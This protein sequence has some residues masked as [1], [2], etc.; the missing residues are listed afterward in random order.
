MAQ[1]IRIGISLETD[2]SG[3]DEAQRS[4]DG[5]LTKAQEIKTEFNSL[6]E[7][8]GNLF[9]DDSAG[10][11]L[12]GGLGSSILGLR[13]EFG[14]AW[15]TGW[16]QDFQGL[17]EGLSGSLT[18]GIQ[19]AL[20]QAG[21]L[22]E[23]SWQQLCQVPQKLLGD[24]FTGLSGQASGAGGMG[25]GLS[26]ILGGLLDGGQEGAGGEESLEGLGGGQTSGGGGGG[27]LSGLLGKSGLLGGVLG[28][29][30]GKGG[31]S[32]L[33]SFLGKGS[34]LT[35]SLLGLLG[36][37][38]ILGG[39]SGAGLL[40]GLWNQGGNLLSGVFG[41]GSESGGLLSGVFG[42]GSESGGLLSGIFGGGSS[43]LLSVAGPL[44]AGLGLT[45]L[46]ANLLDMPGPV[47]AIMGALGGGGGHSKESA[48]S[49]INADMEYL[50]RATKGV[51]EAFATAQVNAEGFATSVLQN[52]SGATEEMGLLADRAGLGSQG[53]EDMVKNLDPLAANLVEASL[54]MADA[55]H[56]I[57][58][59]TQVLEQ[60]D[61]VLG[62]ATSQTDA[63][64]QMIESL[65]ASLNLPAEQADVLNQSTKT[66]IDQFAMGNGTVE[67]LSASLKQ[68]FATALQATARDAKTTYEQMKNLDEAI[69]SIPTEWT[70]H[71]NVVYDTQGDKPSFH[72]GGRIM[73][74]GG[75]LGGLPRFHSGSQVSSLAHD[76]VPI[77]AR[78]GEYIVR[79]ESVNAATLPLLA[80]L[81]QTGQASAGQATSLPPQVNLH[82]EVH[83]NLLGSEDNL[84]ELAR[85]MER[86]L[87]DLDQARYG[88]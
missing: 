17:G 19:S 85:L 15:S 52:M 54:V 49:T 12:G 41:G 82:L 29:A 59:M 76:E 1:D 63:F 77:I 87:R 71:V 78:R 25:A 55:G 74:D 72:F 57:D 39:G 88:A 31:L 11:S 6:S 48:L 62:G 34:G 81:N 16:D 24:M 70:S 27:L 80:A 30:S 83:G 44:G 20:D 5:L 32:L 42:G 50:E 7:E 69:R 68:S 8:T 79:A 3:L 86:K 33:S 60:N 43:G 36:K 61:A 22:W 26:G 58:N 53:L 10:Q 14:Q 37:S 66:L 46:G 4:L 2:S 65:A 23:Q 64:R 40:S 9:G 18:T 67:S 75:W 45:S 13:S 21:P 38:G 28:L 73:H 47:E 56:S 51:E 35:G 84:E